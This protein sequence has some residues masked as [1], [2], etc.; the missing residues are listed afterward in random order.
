[1]LPT[2]TRRI[3]PERALL[4]N[5]YAVCCLAARSGTAQYSILR[6]TSACRRP[7][8]INFNLLTLYLCSRRC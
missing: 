5:C 6:R 8:S 7:L 1:M 3:L 4:A 2:G